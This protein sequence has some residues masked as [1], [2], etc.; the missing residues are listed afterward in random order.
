MSAG[1]RIADALLGSPIPPPNWLDP[2]FA[3]SGWRAPRG[4][5][6]RSYR[7]MSAEAVKVELAERESHLNAPVIQG[8]AWLLGLALLAV[9]IA[10]LTRTRSA[11]EAL[12]LVM[13]L[14]PLPAWIVTVVAAAAVSRDVQLVDGSVFVRSWLGEWLGLRGRRLGAATSIRWSRAS[15]RRLELSSDAGGASVGLLL[16]PSSSV[17]A[18]ERRLRAWSEPPGHHPRRHGERGR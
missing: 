5:R 2:R 17:D 13:V 14:A 15:A 3:G 8:W 9:E 18:L 16:W 7:F 12:T 4:P 11:D 6:L 10:G 1:S